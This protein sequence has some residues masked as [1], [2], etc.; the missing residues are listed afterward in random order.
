MSTATGQ[1][2]QPETAWQQVTIEFT[3]YTKAEQIAAERLRPLLN[4]VAE[5]WWFIR[6]APNW[7]VRYLP[8]QSGTEAIR[9]TLAHMLGGL[10]EERNITNWVE[11][12]Y[13]PEIHAFGGTAAMAVAHQLFHCDS[14][15]ILGNS[16]TCDRRRELTIL[17][18]SALMRGAGQDWY[19]QG[20][21]WARLA[22]NRP[23]PPDINTDQLRT[24]RSGLRRLMS[25][26]ADP[27]SPL[28]KPGGQM[29]DSATWLAAFH[30][31]GAELG[32]LSRAGAL[33]RGLRAVLTHQAIFHW[34]RI[35]LS[36]TTQSV[37]AHAAKATVFDDYPSGERPNFLGIVPPQ[38]TE[39]AEP[40]DV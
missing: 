23:L 16:R 25:V 24:P 7:R 9:D 22:E 3:D 31:A 1:S 11:T 39:A 20:D 18:C 12:I 5:L 40:A 32:V 21:I 19:E 33:H 35:G 2:P 4:A 14:Q 26:D 17:L 8:I 15:H 37:L 38:D 13:E 27:T 34:N 36:Y 29:A 10:R 6:K 28:V 30:R